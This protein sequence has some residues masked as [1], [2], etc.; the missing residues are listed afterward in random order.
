MLDASN[1]QSPVAL[2]FLGIAGDAIAA[3]GTTAYLAAGNLQLIDVSNPA[4]LHVVG[5]AATGNASD[6]M[7]NGTMAYVAN[8]GAGLTVV[9]VSNPSAP[10]IKGSA[11]TPGNAWAVAV[12]GSLACVADVASGL[13][14]IDVSHPMTPRI[15]GSVDTPGNAMDVAVSGSLAYVTDDDPGA[16]FQVVDLSNPRSPVILATLDLLGIANGVAVSGGTAYVADGNDNLQVIDVSNPSS[17]MIIGRGPDEDLSSRKV[18]ASSQFVCVTD[19]GPQGPRN[20]LILPSQCANSSPLLPN[21]GTQNGHV[22]EYFWMRVTATDANLDPL[23]MSLV[24]PLPPWA[25]FIDAGSGAAILRGTPQPGQAGTY[26]ISILASDGKSTTTISFNIVIAPSGGQVVGVDENASLRFRL[27]VSPNPFR[28]GIDLE[29]DLER[30][31]NVSVVI[32]DLQGRKV[33][34]LV[35]G[36]FPAGTHRATWEG[37]DDQG[38]SLGPGVYFARLITGD[39]RVQVQKLFKIR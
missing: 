30:D 16:G 36:K 25:T 34:D 37:R 20:L 31:A 11:D 29:F 38:L 22:L 9:D 1:P 19:A 7:V 8:G 33:R 10:V 18:A 35:S 15:L 28:S 14:V 13:Q 4:S 3:S 21:P 2:G 5:T 39:G 32:L 12:S 24:G 6:V 27:A 17:P 26:P 23:T